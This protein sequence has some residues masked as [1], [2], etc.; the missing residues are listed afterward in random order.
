MILYMIRHGETD[1]NKQKLL[2]G[3][4]DVP[5]NEYGRDLARITALALQ[6]VSFDVIFSS[7]L[8]R[9]RETAELMRLSRKIPILIDERIQEISFGDYEGHCFKGENY[10]LPDPDFNLFFTAPEKYSTPPNGESFAEILERT[11]TFL[12][13]LM[14]NEEYQDKCILI[15]THGCALKALFS[16]LTGCALKDFWGEGVYKNCGVAI[17]EIKDGKIHVIEDGKLYYQMID[18]DA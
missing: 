15:S 14:D 18:F 8:Q 3:R 4:T 10:D 12:R 16:N 2:Q 5:L 13:E 6:E 7:P 9:A 1:K 11:G 17:V